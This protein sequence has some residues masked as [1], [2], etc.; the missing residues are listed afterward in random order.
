MTK[1]TQKPFWERG[2]HPITGFKVPKYIQTKRVDPD[3]RREYGNKYRD[4]V[5]AKNTN[6]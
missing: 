1:S 6:N 5:K 4:K 2:I 3:K